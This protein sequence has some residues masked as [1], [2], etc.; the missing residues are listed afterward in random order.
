M[1]RKHYPFV[2]QY[3]PTFCL[4]LLFL[5][6]LLFTLRL[7]TAVNLTLTAV[8][9]VLLV[10]CILLCR[11]YRLPHRIPAFAALCA[12][13][14]LLGV[15]N[16]A[17]AAILADYTDTE[18]TPTVTVRVESITYEA[19]TSVYFD[20]TITEIDGERTR[21]KAKLYCYDAPLL[22]PGDVAVA[23][24]ELSALPDFGD[25]TEDEVY[26][27]ANGFKAEATLS[28]ATVTGRFTSLSLL[29]S[30]LRD[31]LSAR[32]SSALSENSGGLLCALL[33]GDK[34]GVSPVLSRDMA[35]IG[36]SH[37]LA[38]SGMHFTVL[39]IGIERLLG[40]LRVEKHIRLGF[41]AIASLFYLALTG[42]SASI[43]R[44]GFMLLIMILSFY[45]RQHYDTLTSLGVSL[46]FICLVT[47]YAV[48]H[49]G[50]WLSA[51][52]TF[53][54]LALHERRSEAPT[55]ENRRYS[56][57]RY[58]GDSITIT[59]A[60]LLATA[61][62]TAIAFGTFP[63]L[64]PIANLFLGPL[65]TALLY[66]APLLLLFPRASLL[67]RATEAIA[68][69]FTEASAV[70]SGSDTVLPVSH[71]LIRTVFILTTV[72]VVL[73]VCFSTRKRISL[74]APCAMLLAGAILMS[75]GFQALRLIKSDEAEVVLYSAER[76]SDGEMLL[77]SAE[78]KQ[79][80]IDNTKGKWKP[81]K[82]F[83]RFA[84]EK[85]IYELDFYV[86]TSYE[87]ARS[88]S[89]LYLMES[90]LLREIYLPKPINSDEEAI[91]S[92]L[93]ERAS[94]A[95]STLCLYGEEAFSPSDV[96][97]RSLS[98]YKNRYLSASGF[99][100]SYGDEKILFFS[101]DFSYDPSHAVLIENADT[102]LFGG[103]GSSSEGAPFFSP[104]Q[105]GGV[106]FYCTGLSK[107]PFRDPEGCTEGSLH[108]FIIKKQK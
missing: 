33:L 96:T 85:H 32:L 49:T 74:L 93:K 35:R 89:F 58:L 2:L 87:Q 84:K 50:L 27:L 95:A 10:P 30:R 12:L 67:V 18:L 31:T 26:L 23:T 4:C 98:V 102:V 82:S 57:L 65:I 103:R 60:A 72:S 90:K 41:V 99:S 20:G 53:G 43:M 86:L 19:G 29:L 83:F 51:L 80:V 88:E 28:D 9:C 63:L 56:P 77:I 36:V 40:K 3:R 13:S 73:Y 34:S 48:Y 68:S 25:A 105:F 14:A 54:I 47:P 39:F 69:L 59:A 100:L 64:T 62:L 22:S 107:T 94:G 108:S 38:I 21:I 42:F 75:T 1:T 24:A 7:S 8:F 17:P 5:L 6:S 11:K 70:L 78:G 76:T 37:L 81:Y 52:A 61:P 91:L 92:S 71:P 106:D 16:G 104:I 97:L 44:A 79:G 45:F 15:L 101:A 55:A 66:L 46:F